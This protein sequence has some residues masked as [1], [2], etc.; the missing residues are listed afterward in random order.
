MTWPPGRDIIAP[1]SE[2]E[3]AAVRIAQRALGMEPT[4]LLDEPTKAIL[5]GVQHLFGAE[6]TGVL[7]K[8]TVALLERLRHIYKED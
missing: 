4:G 3:R 5:R 7:D 2:A 8:A 1:A 6:V